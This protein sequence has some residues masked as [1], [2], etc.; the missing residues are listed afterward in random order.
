MFS[1]S[2]AE[3]TEEPQPEQPVQQPIVIQAEQGADN[4]LIGDLLSL[5]IPTGP[6]PSH[7]GG[8]GVGGGLD[9][10]DLL[11]TLGGLD[12]SLV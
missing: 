5:D 6:A 8:G 4:L 2:A 12:V 1:S 10:L 3:S 7:G 11:G 9:D